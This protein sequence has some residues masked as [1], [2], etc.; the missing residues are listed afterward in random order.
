MEIVIKTT[1]GDC[2]YVTV[3]EF[4]TIEDAYN[5]LNPL[6]DPQTTATDVR[7][8]N[9]KYKLKPTEKNERTI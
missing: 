8:N 7:I 9:V 3:Q 6:T 2:G 5:D 1:T 4:R